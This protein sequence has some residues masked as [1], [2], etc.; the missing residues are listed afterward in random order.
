M[1]LRTDTTITCAFKETKLHA[2]LSLFL[3]S[4]QNTTGGDLNQS[5]KKRKRKN[6]IFTSPMKIGIHTNSKHHEETGYIHDRNMLFIRSLLFDLNTNC[7]SRGRCI[8]GA[9]L[10]ANQLRLV[11]LNHLTLIAHSIAGSS[12]RKGSDGS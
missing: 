12:V 9:K 10:K 11:A 6:Q 4:I 8:V 2:Q 1:D 7:N 5:F 3:D